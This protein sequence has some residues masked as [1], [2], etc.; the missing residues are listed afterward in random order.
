M[1]DNRTAPLTMPL[2]RGSVCVV[3]GYGVQ[4]HVKRGHLVVNDGLGAERQERAYSRATHGLSRLVILGHEGFV[5]L[6]ALRWLADLGIAF[7]QVDRDGRVLVTSST[8][9]GDARLRR[10]QALA[11]HTSLGLEIARSI[12]TAKLDGQRAVLGCLT[13]LAEPF[14]AFD[15]WRCS[16]REGASLAGLLEAEREAALIYWGQ[17]SGVECRFST[18]D[19]ARVPT[20]WRSFQQRQS[21]LSSGPR[22]AVTPL[23]ALLNYLYALLEA[24]TRIACLIVGLDPGLGIVHVDYRARD[25]FVLDLMEAGRPAVDEYVLDLART[26]TFGARDFGETRRGVCRVLYPLAHEL[27]RTGHKWRQLIAPHAENVADKLANAREFRIQQLP[28]PL[29]GAR[30]R[31]AGAAGGSVRPPS[32]RPAAIPR[33]RPHPEPLPGCKRCGEPVPRRER[34]YCDVCLPHYQSEQF[35]QAFVN[36]GLSALEKQKAA[37]KDRTHGGEAARRRGDATAQRKVEIAA[38]EAEHGKFIDLSAFEREILPVLQGVPLSRLQ[39]AS[40][41]SLRYVSQIRRGEKRPHPKHW[42]ALRRAALE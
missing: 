18:G 30:R 39:R 29:T 20:H 15:H 1:H 10:Q 22:L 8:G 35:T 3:E 13:D 42:D 32:P 12:L 41:L 19:A 11:P 36:S 31:S 17:W 21:P 28:K 33:R 40:G 27:A 16:L 34:V 26:R 4:V 23:N 9:T 6:D 38:W 7:Q 14:D 2:R 24:E 37:G 5:T 25:S